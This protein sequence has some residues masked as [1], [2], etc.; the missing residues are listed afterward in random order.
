MVYYIITYILFEFHYQIKWKT[1][2][3]TK[4]KV[5]TVYINNKQD[6]HIIVTIKT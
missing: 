5:I 6:V 3:E 4:K 2:K 1:V